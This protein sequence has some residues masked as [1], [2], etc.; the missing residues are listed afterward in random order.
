ML[1]NIQGLH[2]S[3]PQREPLFRNIH[4]Q[5]RDP[6]IYALAG[7]S[8]CGKSTLLQLIYGLLQP[9]KGVLS[10][11]GRAILGP[12]GNIVP[13]E[14]GMQLVAQKFDLM[15][16]ATVYDNVGLA[17]SNVNLTEKRRKVMELLTVTEM[18]AYATEPVQNLSGGQQQRVAIARALAAAPRLLLLDEPFSNLDFSRKSTLRDLLFGYARSNEISIIISTHELLDILPWVDRILVLE[19]GRLIQHDTAE[20]IFLH[21]YN[22]YVARLFG[23]VNVLSAF[24]VEDYQL[25]KALWYAEEI[26]ASPQPS[27]LPTTKKENISA[28]VVNSLFAGTHYRNKVVLENGEQLICHSAMPLTDMAKLSFVPHGRSTPSEQIQI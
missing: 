7:E 3:Y 14:P 23:E 21:P 8:G 15:P 9:A 6:G 27:D 24:T 25:P 26:Q 12:R 4:I 5:L 19:E 18:E 17:I 1:L 28:K 2:F 16:Y 11:A 20:N 22:P 13:G 10:F